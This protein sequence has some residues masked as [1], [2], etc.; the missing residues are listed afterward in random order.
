MNTFYLRTFR[1]ITSIS[2]LFCYTNISSVCA[3]SASRY[4][5]ALFMPPR[6]SLSGTQSS[7]QSL[8]LSL[9]VRYLSR[10]DVAQTS[11]DVAQ[12]EGGALRIINKDNISLKRQSSSK[13][14]DPSNRS[15]QAQHL[16]IIT[17][18]LEVIVTP[19]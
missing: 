16:I 8:S 4:C 11:I 17:V 2:L 7:S 6:C 9:S 5:T 13:P 1:R 3:L 19:I 15:D 10:Q 12:K 18:I 14:T